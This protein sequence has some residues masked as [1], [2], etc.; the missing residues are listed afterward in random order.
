MHKAVKWHCAWYGAPGKGWFLAVASFKAH[1]KLVFLDG[2]SLTPVP[3]VHLA[4][5]PQRALDVR[6]ADKL[7]EAQLAGWVTQASQ[8][9]G[10]GKA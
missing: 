10:W 9:P 4:T 5:R 3:P 8:L 1:L 7:D 6:E 2:D